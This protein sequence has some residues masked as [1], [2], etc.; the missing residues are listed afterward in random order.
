MANQEHQRSSEPQARAQARAWLARQHTDAHELAAGAVGCKCKIAD[1]GFIG[2]AERC[3]DIV[4][5]GEGQC[6]A[7]KCCIRRGEIGQIDDVAGGK[8]DDIHRA[9]TSLIA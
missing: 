4:A 8:A 6:A 2:E 9:Q 1:V 3:L 7:C 5:V